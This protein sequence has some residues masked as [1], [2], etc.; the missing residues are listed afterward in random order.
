MLSFTAKSRK[1]SSGSIPKVDAAETAKEK[2]AFHINTKADPTKAIHEAQPGMF[3]QEGS[4]KLE[5]FTELC[6]RLKMPSRP[7]R[8]N[9]SGILSTAMQMGTS[10]VSFTQGISAR[11]VSNA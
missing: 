4:K 8:S 9:P 11:S 7:P 10:S 3:A 1:T 5:T 6:Q 2:A